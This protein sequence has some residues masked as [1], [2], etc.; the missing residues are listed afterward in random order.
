MDPRFKAALGILAGIVTAALTI[1]LGET[2]LHNISPAPAGF[3]ENNVE[4]VAAFIKGLSSTHWLM[5]LGVYF[6][7]ALIGGYVTHLICRDIKYKPA[8]VVGLGLL[9]TT[10][11]T[12][13]EIGNHPLWVWLGSA[14]AILAGAWIGGRMVR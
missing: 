11:L 13:Y 6:L 9:I 4:S 8:L 12:F 10:F 7:A 14:V 5:L 2:V 3:D 1:F